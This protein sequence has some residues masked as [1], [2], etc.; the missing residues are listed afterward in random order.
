MTLLVWHNGLYK[1]ECHAANKI[2][3]K[4]QFPR[5]TNGEGCAQRGSAGLSSHDVC[6]SVIPNFTTLTH[7]LKQRSSLRGDSQCYYRLY[8]KT[9]ASWTLC[10]WQHTNQKHIC[11]TWRLHTYAHTSHQAAWKIFTISVTTSEKMW[12]MFTFSPFELETHLPP[13]HL[14]QTAYAIK[15]EMTTRETGQQCNH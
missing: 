8:L 7:R 6:L 10:A 1:R 11:S 5:R 2:R 3:E 12:N 14:I 13:H 9:C 15:T 4:Q